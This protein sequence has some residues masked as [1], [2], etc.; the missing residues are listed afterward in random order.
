MWSG[1][2]KTAVGSLRRSKWR[3]IFTMLGIIIGISSVVIIV[4]LGEGLKHDITGQIHD[5]GGDVISVRPG[6]LVSSTNNLNFFALFSASTLSPVDVKNIRQ[7]PS[8]DAAVPI[9]FV[10][11]SVAVDAKE[12]DNIFVA[13]TT[14]ELA[15]LLHQQV[16]YGEFITADNE[17][18]SF[19]VIGADVAQKLFHEAN[20]VG[21]TIKING[22]D[23]I[24]HGVFKR[25]P[26]SFISITQSDFN[27]SVFIPFQ[28]ALDLANGRDNIL[29][30]LVKS[31]H[32]NQVPQTVDSITKTLKKSHRQLDFT[33]L[34]QKD[35]LSLT[36]NVVN[37][38]TGFIGAIAAISL[39]VGGV[40][41]M[42][43]MLVSISERTREIGIRKAVGA[44]NRQILA[45]FLT[46]GLALTLGGGIIGIGISLLINQLLRIYTSWKPI[47]NIW[48]VVLAVGVSIT[49][50]LIFSIA[51]ALK[52][53]RKD[54]ITA[55]RGD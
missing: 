44:T 40:G 41:I 33:V 34:T 17:D 39:L 7:L 12:L 50:G 25:T 55:L 4:S 43:V 9:D 36:G 37:D 11:S 19:A 45:Q 31:K 54:P 14:P 20:P 29:Q 32:L 2:F 8:V 26:N 18:Q 30:I 49:V 24:V 48:V 10:T 42:D 15:R 6:K 13:G 1:N 5:L 21:G 23:F 47:I 53:A 35:L 28:P 3:T 27:S 22:Q 52:A 38:V 51:P 46:E 16:N